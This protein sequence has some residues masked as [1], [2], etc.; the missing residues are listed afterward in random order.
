MRSGRRGAVF[1][2]SVRRRRTYITLTAASLAVLGIACAQNKPAPASSTEVSASLIPLPASASAPIAAPLVAAPAHEPLDPAVLAKERGTVAF[3]D[4]QHHLDA[5]FAQLAQTDAHAAGAVTRILHYG[6][7]IIG[8]DYIS[9]TAR[10]VLQKRFGDSGH[11]FI[12]MTNAWEW[13]FHDDV[14][15]HASAGWD[16]SRFTGPFTKDSAYGIGGVT[17][18]AWPGASATFGTAE[19]GEYGRKVSRFDVYYMEQP[20]GGDF[21]VRMGAASDGKGERVSTAGEAK[22]SRV[23]AFHVPDGEAKVAVRIVGGG[24]TRLFGVALERDTPGVVYD[25]L[26]A[27]GARARYIENMDAAHLREQFALRKPGLIVLAYGTNESQEHVDLAAYKKQFR[28]VIDKM[29]D[30][31]EGASV[32]VMAPPD[33]AERHGGGLRSAPPLVRL[34]EAQREVAR[35][36]GVAFWNTFEAMG[37]SG[38]MAKWVASAPQLGAG[39]LTHPTRAGAARI[40]RLFAD[41]IDT[42]LTAY[43]DRVPARVPTQL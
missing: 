25:A 40:G 43:R 39:D 38:A 9:S 10:R 34:V 20:K 26:G 11:G 18:R 15:H 31:A 19:Q 32:V 42:G 28:A 5:F 27:L 29:R 2:A 37:G 14:V 1:S 16:M 13:Y 41:A 24:E 21:E 23:H 33:R 8:S 35:E 6:D 3:D 4:P 36:A 7:S 12:L 22:V 30:A 17:F